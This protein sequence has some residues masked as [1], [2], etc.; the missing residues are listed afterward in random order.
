MAEPPTDPAQEAL[1]AETVRRFLA[2]R[3]VS[4][5]GCGYNLRGNEQAVCPECGRGIELTIS[6]PGRGR[7]YLLFVIL[8]LGWV[9]TAGSMNAVRTWKEVR[10]QAQP[11]PLLTTAFRTSFSM[12]TSGGKTTIVTGGGGPSA[13]FVV[14][15]TTVTQAP[16]PR[17]PRG[18]SMIWGNVAQSTWVSLGWWAGLG[19]LSLPALILAI[20]RRRRFDGERLPRF[21]IG[22]A[23][24][25]FIMYAGYHA[26]HFMREVL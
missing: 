21:T 1:A 15:G 23:G 3:D 13:T 12:T 7:G 5:P 22:A 24:V 6:R 11:R 26:V 14:N 19:A 10:T 16:P 18:Q 9:L 17:T 8:A 4:C 20:A 25:L 2:E